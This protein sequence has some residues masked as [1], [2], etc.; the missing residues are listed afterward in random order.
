MRTLRYAAILAAISSCLLGCG[1]GLIDHAGSRG[2]EFSCR[3]DGE[4]WEA[5][6]DI[7]GG[8]SI[9]GEEGESYG[10]IFATTSSHSSGIKWIGL[11][12]DT[13]LKLGAQPIHY[14]SA[15]EFNCEDCGEVNIT[16]LDRDSSRIA[17]TFSFEANNA[18]GDVAG[19]TAGAFD[20]PFF[21]RK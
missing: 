8:A 7:A 17:G 15:G 20:V 3:V 12:F 18:A 11:Q 13:P 2:R 4:Y 5:R 21:F 1:P 9:I 19:I 14:A 16:L 10:R 6:Y